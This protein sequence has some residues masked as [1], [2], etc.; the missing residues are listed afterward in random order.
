MS[1]HPLIQNATRRPYNETP[2]MPDG[3]VY[4]R[5][6][7]YWLYKGEPLVENDLF[8]MQHGTKKC[9]E[10]TGEDQKGE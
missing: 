8:A 1:T 9:D 5:V 4:D 6:S 10:E 3:S 2:T 7:G